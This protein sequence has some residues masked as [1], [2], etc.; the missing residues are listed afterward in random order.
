MLKNILR[1]SNALLLPDRALISNNNYSILLLITEDGYTISENT[2]KKNKVDSLITPTKRTSG[3]SPSLGN[4][5]IKYVFPGFSDQRHIEYMKTLEEFCLKTK[6]PYLIRLKE[7]LDDITFTLVTEDLSN[8]IKRDQK[9]IICNAGNYSPGS[10]V[11]IRFTEHS[12]TDHVSKI[13]TNYQVDKL[14]D[15][16]EK[17]CCSVCS[18]HGGILENIPKPL[19]E[20]YS[21]NN[22]CSQQYGNTNSDICG[23]CAFKINSVLNNTKT[24]HLMIG[25]GASKTVYV[26]RHLATQ[27]DED[28]DNLINVDAFSPYVEKLHRRRELYRRPENIELFLVSE[29]NQGRST[30]FGMDV[31]ENIYQFFIEQES[32]L[33]TTQYYSIND[34]ANFYIVKGSFI[35]REIARKMFFR[36]ALTRQLKKKS[37]LMTKLLKQVNRWHQQG[38]YFDISKMKVILNIL[39]VEMSENLSVCT[40]GKLLANMARIQKAKGVKRTFVE[41]YAHRLVDNPQLIGKV[42]TE[43]RKK[44]G[45]DHR[46][47]VENWEKDIENLPSRKLTDSET[48]AFHVAIDTESKRLWAAAK[49]RKEKEE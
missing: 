35:D 41:R 19:N 38:T 36:Y 8:P 17:R 40:I 10:F 7:V 18:Q 37:W 33:S 5:Q 48:L 49:E 16:S 12:I 9:R 42:I 29:N 45:A 31:I 3:I 26:I 30:Y 27:E 25:K 15:T 23:E 32:Y 43:F 13:W 24:K 6:N 47:D 11:G 2:D 22:K 14:K 20:F 39:G 44:Y 28:N 21:S 1:L 34:L 4:D 46:I